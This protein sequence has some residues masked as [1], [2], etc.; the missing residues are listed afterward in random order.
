MSVSGFL[1]LALIQG[2]EIKTKSKRKQPFLH[3]KRQKIYNWNV[4]LQIVNII[5]ISQG[6]W[7]S[8]KVPYKCVQGL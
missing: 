4:P 2:R 8:E 1:P 5:T 7:K 6:V 3:K